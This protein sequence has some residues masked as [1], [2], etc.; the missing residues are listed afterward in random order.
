MV[1]QTT[2]LLNKSRLTIMIQFFVSIIVKLLMIE[3]KYKIFYMHSFLQLDTK[4]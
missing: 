1:Q 4:L 3:K 2:L